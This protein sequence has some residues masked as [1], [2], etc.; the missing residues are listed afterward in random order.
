MGRGGGNRLA[1]C[2]VLRTMRIE[3]VALAVIGT[4]VLA[5]ACGGGADG[6]SEPVAPDLVLLR[7]AL[8]MDGAPLDAE[9][10]GAR[11]LKD[12]LVTPCQLSIPQVYGGAYEI[13]VASEG[14]DTAGCGE[15][16]ARIEFWTFVDEQWLHSQETLEWPGG[17][18]T[19][20]FDASFST[21]APDGVA[22]PTTGIAGEAFRS[23]GI[24]VP[25]GTRIEAYVGDVLCG[26]ASVRAGMGADFVSSGFALA[27]VDASSVP[28]CDVGATVTFRVDGL[29]VTQTAV[30]DLVGTH[31]TLTVP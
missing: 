6:P 21:A 3:L 20:T 11:V 1:R 9:F 14:T 26:I 18:V 5:S 15:P 30:H 31:I 29:P 22:P 13:R 4:A 8:T 24:S 10:L 16:G 28:G 23:D 12:G 25:V 19:A 2:G 7:G 17:G 27:V